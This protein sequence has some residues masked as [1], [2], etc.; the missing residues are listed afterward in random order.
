MVV[1]VSCLTHCGPFL[2]FILLLRFDQEDNTGPELDNLI[3][4]RF[5]ILKSDFFLLLDMLSYYKVLKCA[6]ELT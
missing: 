1:G 2:L 5:Y 6:T 3:D 4:R